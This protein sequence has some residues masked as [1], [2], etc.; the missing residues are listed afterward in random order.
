MILGGFFSVTSISFLMFCIFIVGL[1]GYALGRIKIRGISL[2][3]AGVFIVAL[4]FGAFFFKPLSEQLMLVAKVQV[5]EE[6]VNVSVGY[7]SNALK[8]IEGL[9]LP[10]HITRMILIFDGY[11]IR[12][13]PA[14]SAP[15]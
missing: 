8:I 4:V 6:A 10:E 5:A 14:V 15:P 11:C 7:I 2:G 1:L 12:A 9:I 3:T 13:V